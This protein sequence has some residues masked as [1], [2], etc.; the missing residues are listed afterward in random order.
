MTKPSLDDLIVVARKAVE[1]FDA[2][3]K[4]ERDARVRRLE[5]AREAAAA[6]LQ[7]RDAGATQV[8]IARAVNKS[9]PWVSSMLKWGRRSHDNQ[10]SVPWAAETNNGPF[11][12]ASQAA[13]ERQQRESLA[14]GV[15]SHKIISQLP[16]TDNSP[17]VSAKGTRLEDVSK[18][19]HRVLNACIDPKADNAT[20][21]QQREVGRD[22][23]RKILAD[24]GVKTVR[25]L[26]P[27]QFDS[28]IQ[29][30]EHQDDAID[31]LI[32]RAEKKIADA[33]VIEKG[34]KRPRLTTDSDMA[35]DHFKLACNMY[36]CEMNLAGIDA[37]EAY[38]KE[39]AGPVC[40]RLS[41]AGDTSL[42]DGSKFDVDG[43]V[44]PLRKKG[45]GHV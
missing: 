1:A 15:E 7:A 5:R 36:I 33:T 8:E 38:F 13:R 9:Q 24:H 27:E 31:D 18:A 29:A 34:R 12:E 39:V 3:D 14:E 10:T 23:A 35:L 45:G 20:Q 28:V 6:M 37:A 44:V 41:A 26:K 4:S 25:D 16:A 42:N 2:A 11:A 19:L 32:A 22:A 40:A 30:C 17:K 43:N 21:T